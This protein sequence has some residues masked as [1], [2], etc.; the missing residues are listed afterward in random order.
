MWAGSGVVGAGVARALY[1]GGTVMPWVDGVAVYSSAGLDG[2]SLNK[3][4]ETPAVFGVTLSVLPRS[5]PARWDRGAGVLVR[6]SDDVQ[7]RIELDILNGANAAAI[8]A[9]GV[10]DWEVFQFANADLQGDG[11]YRLHGLLRGQAG[12]EW[13]VPDLWPVGAEIVLLGAG[14]TQIELAVTARGLTRNYRVGPADK[15][16]SDMLY[17]QTAVAFDGVGLRPYAPVHLRAKADGAG[18]FNITW[19]RRTRIDGDSWQSVEVPLGEA[20]EAYHLRVWNGATLLRE[21]DVAAPHWAYGASEI[22]ADAASG[23]IA[24]ETAQIST[25]FGT[26]PYNRITINV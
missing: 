10:G 5:Q 25:R 13:L 2:F 6:F 19:I 21:A 16:V 11:S 4:F 1:F 26:G 7:S 22:A 17:Q 15:P 12:T 20:Q 14:V 24:I 18:G 9:N 8:R 3:R 23:S